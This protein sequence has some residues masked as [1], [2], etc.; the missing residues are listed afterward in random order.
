NL[1][2]FVIGAARCWNFLVLGIASKQKTSMHCVSPSHLCWNAAKCIVAP[3]ALGRHPMKS[4]IV[5]R[6]I[7]VGGHKTSVSLEDA[8]WNL[9][10]EIAKGRDET[11]SDLVGE[12]DTDRQH[13]NLSSAIR[14]FVLDRVRDQA[15]PADAEHASQQTNMV[16]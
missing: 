9:L 11:V 15:F 2:R 10:K 6:S 13:G 7:V 16:A 8:F 1:L 5:K 3:I 12:I 4:S 14:L